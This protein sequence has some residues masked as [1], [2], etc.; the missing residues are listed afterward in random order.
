[1]LS[2][3]PSSETLEMVK[4]IYIVFYDDYPI[5]EGDVLEYGFLGA[6]TSFDLA[7]DFRH[8]LQCGEDGNR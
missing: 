2:L 6:F 8:T 3:I 7:S 5:E 1:M 4:K